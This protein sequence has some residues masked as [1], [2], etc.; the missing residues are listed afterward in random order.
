MMI[1]MHKN[2]KASTTWGQLYEEIYI[3]MKGDMWTG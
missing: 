1:H 3:E 2:S